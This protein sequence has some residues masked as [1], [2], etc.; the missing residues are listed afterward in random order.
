SGWSAGR[1]SEK[2]LLA[3][4]PARC[5]LQTEEQ[6]RSFELLRLALF[7]LKLR[8]LELGPRPKEEWIFE[9]R[10]NLLRHVIFQQL[11]TL[12]HLDA[13]EQAMQLIKA[14]RSTGS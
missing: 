2:F 11:V 12:E 4:F 1:Q 8:K 6:K 7:A 9:F 5:T 13:H 3:N 10:C 14:C